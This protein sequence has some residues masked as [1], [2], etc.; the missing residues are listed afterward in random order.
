MAIGALP[1]SSARQVAAWKWSIGAWLALIALGL[2][3]EL[4]LA[5]LRPGG[6]WLALKIVPMLLP[7]PAL[8]RGSAYAMQLAL[9]I[10]LL[11]VLEGAVR[12][13][14][15]LPAGGLAALE[16]LLTA[17]FFVAAIVYLRPMKLA[18]KRARPT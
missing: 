10:V 4:V 6:S 14:E 8:L 5:P 3:W 11:F 18:S 17:L 15:P 9:F 12:I 2:G 13:F 16:L 7:L 1:G